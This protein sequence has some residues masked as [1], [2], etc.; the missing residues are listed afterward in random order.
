MMVEA[1]IAALELIKEKEKD[2]D[3]NEKV[4][5]SMDVDNSVSTLHPSAPKLR[6]EVETSGTRH[7][8]GVRSM[9]GGSR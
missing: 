6:T 4:S 9:C 3:L 2:P 7:S 1:R 5:T 8:P